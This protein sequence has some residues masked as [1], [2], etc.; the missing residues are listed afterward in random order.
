[1]SYVTFVHCGTYNE[2]VTPHPHYSHSA[3]PRD[4]LWASFYQ[5]SS[6]G[7]M[8]GNMLDARCRLFST[9]H[10]FGASFIYS[11]QTK[12]KPLSS[13]GAGRW[14]MPGARSIEKEV[15]AF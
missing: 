4:I 9:V 12:L 7:A 8:K 14:K 2:A 5:I 15:G 13:P 6:P 10:I 3:R 1:M 11:V